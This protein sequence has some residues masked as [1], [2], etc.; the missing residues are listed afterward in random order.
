MPYLPARPSSGSSIGTINT[1]EL[2]LVLFSK[3]VDAIGWTVSIKRQLLLGIFSPHNETDALTNSCGVIT[4]ALKV[5]NDQQQ[6][7]AQFH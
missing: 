6:D 2:G 5:A 4:N 1:Y 3:V 7:Q